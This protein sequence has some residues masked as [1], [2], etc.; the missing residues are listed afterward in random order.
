MDAAGPLGPAAAI[1]KRCQARAV[2]CQAL[3]G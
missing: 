2:E 1:W 3:H